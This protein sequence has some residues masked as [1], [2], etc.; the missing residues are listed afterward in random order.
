LTDAIQLLLPPQGRL[1]LVVDRLE[2]LFTLCEDEAE[3]QTFLDA[4]IA[5]IHHPHCPA[6]VVATMRADF[7]AHL[8]LY[9]N[10]ASQVVGHQ[11]YLG[12]MR[13][14]D[15]AEIIEA[16]AAQ[17]GAIFEKGLAMQV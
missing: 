4:L 12:P 13:E 8:G 17:V 14:E 2:E 1:I 9:D 11:I 7:Y 16:P 3:R 10:L 15:V 5:L 6:W